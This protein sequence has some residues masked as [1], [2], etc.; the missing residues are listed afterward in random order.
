MGIVGRLTQLIR[1]NLNDLISKSEDPEKM[2]NQ[3][4]VD[5]TTQ[6]AEVKQQV[7][8]VMAQEKQL[9]RQFLTHKQNA[10]EWER[11]AML[12]VR[13]GD[14]GLA[15]E[16]LLRQKELEG[17]ATEF[18]T[19]WK[20]QQQAT[21]TLKNALTLLGNKIEEAKR[22]RVVLVA[23]KKRAEAM[24]KI[25]GVMGNLQ[26]NSLFEAFKRQEEK[27]NEMEA[28]ADASTQLHEEQTGDNLN[29]KFEELEVSRGADLALEDLK[30]KMGITA[31]PVA[32]TVKQEKP[33]AVRVDVSP[34]EA[35]ISK[36]AT[37]PSSAEA[38]AES[39]ELERVLQEMENR[40]Q[41]RA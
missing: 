24:D 39:A 7:A 30:R 28:K 37:Q 11:K 31:P 25:N 10:Q 21:N 35:E 23:R 5:M 22:K 15:K 34:L 18:E 3:I 6:F 4:I 17:L 32:V 12:A 29:K 20:K 1:S 8:G 33:V 16:A 27:I 19:Q 26:D 14:D 41:K 38:E 9:E 40:R 13:A 36:V 2:L